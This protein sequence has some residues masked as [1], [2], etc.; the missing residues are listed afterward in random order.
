M[1]LITIKELAAEAAAQKQ[2]AAWQEH[3]AQAENALRSAKTQKGVVFDGNRIDDLY[4]DGDRMWFRRGSSIPPKGI[5]QKF[6]GK[7]YFAS[8]TDN[9]TKVEKKNA[10]TTRIEYTDGDYMLVTVKDQGNSL[11]TFSKAERQLTSS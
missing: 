6:E 9:I 8:D 5:M 1:N 10:K 2:E 3:I 7:W 11:L 4:I